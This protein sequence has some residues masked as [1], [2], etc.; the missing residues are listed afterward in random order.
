MTFMLKRIEKA[1]GPIHN[2]ALSFFISDKFILRELV[3]LDRIKNQ[4]VV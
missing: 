4:I 1:Q 3:N 2:G